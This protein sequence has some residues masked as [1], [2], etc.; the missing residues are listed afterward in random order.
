M[1]TYGNLS[2]VTSDG[3]EKW[4]FQTDS[5]KGLLSSPAI[6]PDGSIFFTVSPEMALYAVNPNGTKKWKADATGWGEGVWDFWE[7]PPA[8]SRDGTILI[9]PYTGHYHNGTPLCPLYAV[10][11]NGTLSW[12]FELHGGGLTSSAAIGS[13]GTIYIGSS[14]SGLYANGNKGSVFQDPPPPTKPSGGDPGSGTAPQ[15]N[16][17]P[18]PGPLVPPTPPPEKIEPVSTKVEVGRGGIVALLVST[19]MVCSVMLGS[20]V[21]QYSCFSFASMFYSKKKREEILDNF[22]RGQLF[23]RI[24]ENPG[25]SLAE[26][27]EKVNRSSGTI[28]YHLRTLEREGLIKS[29]RQGLNRLFFPGSMRIQ[30]GLLDLRPLQRLILSLVEKNPGISQQEL[31]DMTEV[32]PPTINRHIHD[33]EERGLITITKGSKTSCY[34]KK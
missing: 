7:S 27:T 18:G 6:G 25:L 15:N 32:S 14:D 8:V 23:G 28:V 33:L 24:S 34:I 21:G 13:D 29:C 31:S 10:N 12:M 16:S 4:N 9:A 2:A 22:I 11:P 20:E 1:T 17:N 26:L 30:E 19:M 3:E 5:T